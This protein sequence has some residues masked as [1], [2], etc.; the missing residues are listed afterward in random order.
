M[1]FD[2]FGSMRPRM[3]RGGMQAVDVLRN[4]RDV[5][6]G[7]GGN[8]R[9]CL[10]SRVGLVRRVLFR[11]EMRE[12]KV[13]IEGQRI[14]PERFTRGAGPNNLAP[15]AFLAAEGTDA[16]VDGQTGASEQHDSFA[17]AYLV[18]QAF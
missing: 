11:R 2:E 14:G 6:T 17:A 18:G 4:D 15:Q 13:V 12:P 7:Q 5:S 9:N 8:F 10:V 16:A 3:A 1:R